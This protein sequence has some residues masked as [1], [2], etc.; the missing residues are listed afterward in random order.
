MCQNRFNLP[1]SCAWTDIA[2]EVCVCVRVRVCV[3][4]G[5]VRGG[6]F[7]AL[8]TRSRNSHLLTDNTPYSLFA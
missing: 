7:I 5:G 4:V 3:W 1:Q 8:S 2:V 6:Q